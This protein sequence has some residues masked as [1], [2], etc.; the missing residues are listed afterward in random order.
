MDLL[1]NVIHHP[2]KDIPNN[3]IF[4][5]KEISLSF[6]RTTKKYAPKI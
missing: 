1:T 6:T 3:A 2:G 5:L 4:P